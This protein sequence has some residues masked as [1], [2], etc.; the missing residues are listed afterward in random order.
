MLWLTRASSLHKKE[1]VMEENKELQNEELENV[2]EQT[3]DTETPLDKYVRL[4]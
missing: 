1:T 4:L 3:A 2:S